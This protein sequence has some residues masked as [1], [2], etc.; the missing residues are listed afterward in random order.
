MEGMGKKFRGAFRG[1]W[2]LLHDSELTKGQPAGHCPRICI[3]GGMAAAMLFFFAAAVS[4][5]AID[6]FRL[7]FSKQLFKGVNENDAMA[8]TQAW[9]DAFTRERKVEVRPAAFILS[10]LSEIKTALFE[11]S[12]D[13]I[14]MTTFEYAQI[15]ELLA[16]DVVLCGVISDSIW[17]EYILLVNRKSNIKKLSD[18]KGRTLGMLSTARA[19]LAETWL[20]TLLLREGLGPVT[21]FFDRVDED[22][23]PRNLL[24]SLFFGKLDACVVTRRGFEI[25]VELNPQTGKQLDILEISQPMVPTSLW[26]RKGYT[27]P[28]RNRMLSEILSWHLTPTGKQSLTI[29][30]TDNLE[31]QPIT[32]LDSA[33]A[34]ISEHQ[35]LV[36]DTGAI[37][38]GNR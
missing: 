35:R 6:S 9:A 32:C 16:D 3:Y 25:M 29:F 15:R 17:E 11:E 37:F 27:S 14:T 2:H 22:L 18:L 24:L 26:F 7:G 5:Q 1:L 30:Q 34:L 28:I 33:L 13:A 20:D 8:V 21:G 12:V 19:S 4:G 36:G 23:K 10:G 38:S 31:K